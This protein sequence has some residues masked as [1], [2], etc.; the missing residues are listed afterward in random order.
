M[1]KSTNKLTYLTRYGIYAV[2]FILV[3]FFSLSNERFFTVENLLLILQQASP[4]GIAVVGMVFVLLVAGIDIS[5]GRSMF[6]ISTIIG[7]LITTTQTIPPEYF[8]DYRGILIVLAIVLFLGAAVGFLNGLLTSKFRIL[9]FIVTLATG[10]ILRGIGLQISDSSS[11]D[12][13]VLGSLS[14]GRVLN[15]P[16]V[17]ICFVIVIAIF[18]YVLRHTEY[19]RH[20][21]AIGNSPRNAERTG[22][23]VKRNIIIAYMICGSLGALGGILSAGQIGSVAASFA[24]GNE[25]I[26][27]SAAVLGG[28]SLFGGKGNI[29]PGAIIGIIL[30]T[31]IMNGLAMI[32]ASPFIY[33]IAKGLII[34]VA[35]ALDSINYKGELR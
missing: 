6:V 17:F 14:N 31:T 25:F 11:I 4:L 15:I 33:T 10:S 28:A 9:P 1:Q 18:D 27:I 24:V 29:F 3:I 20:L 8:N 34:F 26:V 35:V 22:I 13:A 7:F 16:N 30:I 12:V 5:V 19:G 32:N 23:N 2:F 21:M